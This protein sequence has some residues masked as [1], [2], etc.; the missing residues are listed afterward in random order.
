MRYAIAAHN[1]R[2]VDA[3]KLGHRIREKGHSVSYIFVDA[4]HG[5]E[6]IEYIS[7]LLSR[8]DDICV[9]IPKYGVLRRWPLGYSQV[10]HVQI[11]TGVYGF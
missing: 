3:E 8:D 9:I 4:I 6:V 2:M 7:P 1:S 5:E 11:K 10:D